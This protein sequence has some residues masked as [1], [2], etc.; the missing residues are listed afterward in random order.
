MSKFRRELDFLQDIEDA[1][2]RALE[3]TNGLA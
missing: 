1:I 2:D 3:Y